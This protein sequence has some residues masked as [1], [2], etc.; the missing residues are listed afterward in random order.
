MTGQVLEK[1]DAPADIECPSIVDHIEELDNSNQDEVTVADIARRKNKKIMIGAVATMAF[2]I[3][4]GMAIGAVKTSHQDVS[5]GSSAAAAVISKSSSKSSKKSKAPAKKK[6]K[7]RKSSS[8]PSSLPSLQPSTSN[9]PSHEPSFAPSL[10][11][12]PSRMPSLHPSTSSKPSWGPSLS[13][14]LSVSPS[15]QPSYEKCFVDNLELKNAAG[16]YV[17]NAWTTADEDKY[18]PIE[19]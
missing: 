18:G 3:G 13:P 9:K 5:I 15:S 1:D 6:G 7:A 19:D 12:S 2:S 11:S 16:R 10:S 4:T 17:G 14:S 8:Y